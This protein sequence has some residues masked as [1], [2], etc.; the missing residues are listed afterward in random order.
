MF[1]MDLFREANKKITDTFLLSNIVIQRVRQLHEGADPLVDYDDESNVD[2]ALKEIAE[3]K[4]EARKEDI[5]TGQ[6][7]FAPAE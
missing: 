7:L 4:I 2:L 3:G 5:T 1:N 6:D